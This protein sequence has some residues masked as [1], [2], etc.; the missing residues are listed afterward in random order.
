MTQ[1]FLGAHHPNW[2]GL[3]PASLFVSDARLRVRGKDYAGKLKH[4]ALAPWGLDSGAFSEVSKHGHH[5]TSAA[6]YAARARRYHAEIGKLAFASVQ[7]W[8][9]EPAVLKVTGLSIREHQRRTV[10]S[11]LELRDHAP[12]VPWMPVLQG[13]GQGDHFAH[14]EMYD[15][16]GIDLRQLPRVG[17][18][19]V[20]RRQGEVRI[21]LLLSEL[22]AEGLSLHAFGVKARGIELALGHFDSADSMAWSTHERREHAQKRSWDP[23]LPKTG[24]QNDLSAALDWLGNTVEA[25]ISRARRASA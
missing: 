18:G 12:E 9:C 7:D 23:T 19:S 20:C 14:L 24:R 13:W 1:F 10:D 2:L 21:S 16:A 22:R 5:L 25:A 17:F 8:M 11:Y 4:R 15:A 3:S 6:S